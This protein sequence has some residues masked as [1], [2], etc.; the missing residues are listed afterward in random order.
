[1]KNE[2]KLLVVS[3]NLNNL[4]VNINSRIQVPGQTHVQIV[5]NMNL[6]TGHLGDILTFRIC[7]QVETTQIGCS[8]LGLSYSAK[9]IVVSYVLRRSIDLC[10]A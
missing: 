7:F 8:S 10:R 1:M 4:K 5:R 6:A 9:K 3:V 2:A